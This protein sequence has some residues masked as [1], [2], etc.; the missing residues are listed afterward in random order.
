MIFIFLRIRYNRLDKLEPTQW[1]NKCENSISMKKVWAALESMKEGKIFHA[2]YPLMY[3]F[4][5]IW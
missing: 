5:S 1:N 3:F 2:H 4:R